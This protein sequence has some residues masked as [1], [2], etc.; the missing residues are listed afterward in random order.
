MSVRNTNNPP[1]TCV[2]WSVTAAE[3]NLSI[4]IKK[5]NSSAPAPTTT[6]TL[7]SFR[8]GYGGMTAP[9][10][11]HISRRI[12]SRSITQHGER[13]QHPLQLI[14][15]LKMQTPHATKQ[16]KKTPKKPLLQCRN[17]RS[18]SRDVS[19]S[20]PPPTPTQPPDKPGPHRRL[21]ALPA[22]GAGLVQES[23]TTSRSWLRAQH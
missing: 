9:S 11:L 4:H 10:C 5:K 12:P 22:A 20:R 3:C 7:S 23:G 18:P 21:F 2:L 14:H 19:P 15:C 8:W 16:K 13:I 17:S 1:R 6:P